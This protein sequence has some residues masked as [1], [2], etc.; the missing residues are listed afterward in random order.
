MYLNSI[1][2]AITIKDLF[3]AMCSKRKVFVYQIDK[4]VDFFKDLQNH[5]DKLTC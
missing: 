5:E 3:T 1:E 2:E 4:E